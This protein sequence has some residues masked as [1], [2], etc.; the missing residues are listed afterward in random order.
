MRLRAY[1]QRSRTSLWVSRGNSHVGA[2]DCIGRRGF[3]YPQNRG[4]TPTSQRPKRDSA[5]RP[6]N[7]P[8]WAQ[9]ENALSEVR[10][11]QSNL[12]DLW[13]LHRGSTPE[14]PFFVYRRI[15]LGPSRTN[16]VRETAQTARSMTESTDAGPALPTALLLPCWL[17]RW[18][19][20]PAF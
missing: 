9:G 1:N 5:H 8:K 12:T 20:I 6:T 15:R 14:I 18:A 4:G 19:T 11:D 10:S 2:G 3:R 7:P 13:S 17:F 16:F